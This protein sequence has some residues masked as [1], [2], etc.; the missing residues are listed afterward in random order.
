MGIQG[1]LQLLKPAQEDCH[2]S[3]FKNQ[4]AVIDIMV[5][6]YKGAFSCAFEL[7]TD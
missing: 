7:A 5:W 1:L 2:I 6:L 4:T 3:K